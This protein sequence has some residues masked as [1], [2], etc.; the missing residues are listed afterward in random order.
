MN[1]QYVATWKSCPKQQV[2]G[3]VSLIA[4][5]DYYYDQFPAC[6]GFLVNLGWKPTQRVAVA[7]GGF[8]NILYVRNNVPTLEKYLN[9]ML[10]QLHLVP[11]SPMCGD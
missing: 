7:I 2:P 8:N 4:N 1:L 11:P 9:S 5:A 10:L 3:V 6:S